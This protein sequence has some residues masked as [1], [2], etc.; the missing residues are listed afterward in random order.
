MELYVESFGDLLGS[1][2][3]ENEAEE[4]ECRRRGVHQAFIATASTLLGW[5][6]HRIIEEYHAAYHEPIVLESGEEIPVNDDHLE[7]IVHWFNAAENDVSLYNEEDFIVI[8][9]L[10]QRHHQDDAALTQDRFQTWI[11]ETN[12]K[13]RDQFDHLMLRDESFDEN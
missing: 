8:E 4:E 2:V 9:R 6:T 5:E 1:D 12:F 11:E 10:V 7:R 3:L 13:G